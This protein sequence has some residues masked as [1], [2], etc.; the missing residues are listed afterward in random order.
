M[1]IELGLASESVRE[2]LWRQVSNSPFSSWPF[3][4]TPKTYANRYSLNVKHY[5]H[6]FIPE[7]PY[8]LPLIVPAWFRGDMAWAAKEWLTDGADVWVNGQKKS[9]ANAWEPILK[10]F[11]EGARTLPVRATNCFCAATRRADGTLRAT[12]VDPSYLEP[13]ERRVTLMCCDPISS[14]RDVISGKTVPYAGQEANL[15]IPAGAFRIL[16]L[17]P[18]LAP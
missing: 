12:L 17:K 3:L 6:S 4:A 14:L 1:D 18:R 16:D 11:V 8:G 9:A 10:S 7:T 15:V 2:G 5:S 13:E